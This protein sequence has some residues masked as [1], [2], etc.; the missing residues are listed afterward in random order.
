MMAMCRASFLDQ[1]AECFLPH[2]AGPNH[3][4]LLVIEPL[5]QLS[6]E[7]RYSNAGNTDALLV[8]R[9]LAGHAF[10]DADGGLE[11]GMC[12]R[13]GHIAGHGLLVSL[14]DL[15][16]DLGFPDH[17]AVETGRH[18]EK[19]AHRLLVVHFE[20]FLGHGLRVQPME[21][22]HKLGHFGRAG[23]W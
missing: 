15:R 4:D 14:L 20:Q 9:R 10:G 21:I 16:E 12:Q 1:I 19:V 11:H 7:V 17:H 2:L 22:C 6:G 8:D 3:Q 5:E 18:H 13:S 23:Q